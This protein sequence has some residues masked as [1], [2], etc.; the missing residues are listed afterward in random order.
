MHYLQLANSPL[1]YILRNNLR[2]LYYLWVSFIITIKSEN[3][4][5]LFFALKNQKVLLA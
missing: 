3:Y 1:C 5:F 2:Y 4:L